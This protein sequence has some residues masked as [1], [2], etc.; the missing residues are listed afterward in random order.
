M[1]REDL[2]MA[3]K[4][5]SRKVLVAKLREPST[6]EKHVKQQEDAYLPRSVSSLLIL[7][8]AMAEVVRNTGENSDQ[9][10]AMEKYGFWRSGVGS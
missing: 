9:Y 6:A 5:V 4:L 3:Q 2:C 8:R 7:L 1:M 10:H